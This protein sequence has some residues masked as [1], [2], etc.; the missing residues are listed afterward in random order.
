MQTLPIENVQDY[1]RPP[2]L[3]D[4]PQHRRVM[5]ADQVA[6]DTTKGQRVLETHHAPTYYFPRDDIR[7][8]LV[9]VGG[10]SFCEWKGHAQYFDVVVA[11]TVARRAAWTYERPSPSFSRIAGHVAF[12][13]GLVDACFVGDERVIP[14]PGDFYGGWVTANLIGTPKGSRGTMHW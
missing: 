2:S 12:Y 8:H 13:A 14:Q 9:P 7:A 1:P 5:L 3:A 6:A 11:G 10:G 4:V